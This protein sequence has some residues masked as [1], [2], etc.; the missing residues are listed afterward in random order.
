[1]HFTNTIFSSNSNKD[2]IS[3]NN[4]TFGNVILENSRTAE[5]NKDVKL[6]LDQA[7]AAKEKKDFN[8]VERIR[9]QVQKSHPSEYA[10]FQKQ[11]FSPSSA[12]G[13]TDD[14]KKEKTGV[15]SLIDFAQ[16]SAKGVGKPA[17]Q[18][19]ELEKERVKQI[20]L[21]RGWI[22]SADL[23]EWFRV[24]FDKFNLKEEVVY[25]LLNVAHNAS[26]KS[27]VDTQTVLSLWAQMYG[28]FPDT[29]KIV[30][31][32]N[33]TADLQSKY[34]SYG[35][36][37]ALRSMAISPK[38]NNRYD[39]DFDNET[40]NLIWQELKS[41]VLRAPLEDTSYL[42]AQWF[43]S[44]NKI[45]RALEKAERLQQISDQIDSIGN[46]AAA[47]MLIEQLT[48]MNKLLQSQGWYKALQGVIYS[49]YA[50]QKA[51]EVFS[52][53]LTNTSPTVET[54]TRPTM[55]NL[56]NQPS[57]SD[58]AKQ[59][60][61]SLNYRQVLAQAD[62]SSKM[63]DAE[64]RFNFIKNE[65]VKQLSTLKTGN[66]LVDT[67]IQTFVNFITNSNFID[68]L[69]GNFKNNITKSLSSLSNPNS[70]TKKSSNVSFNKVSQIYTSIFTAPNALK[71]VSMA[72]SVG[73]IALIIGYFRKNIE[74]YAKEPD[75]LIKF[76]L[77]AVNYLVEVLNKEIIGDVFGSNLERDSIFYNADGTV[78]TDAF[79]DFDA[80][81]LAIGGS[82]QDAQAIATL[83]NVIKR[84]ITM[85]EDLENTVNSQIER[86]VQAGS[87]SK[88]IR[89]PADTSAKF[90]QNLNALSKVIAEAISD[91]SML[92]SLYDRILSD[93]DKQAIDPL[94]ASFIGSGRRRAYSNQE[95]LRSKRQRYASIEVIKDEIAKFIR[96]NMLL[97]PIMA[98]VKKFN[99]LGMS[100]APLIAESKSNPNSLLKAM[101][102]IRQNEQNKI[103]KVQKKINEI[104]ARVPNAESY[105]DNRYIGI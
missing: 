10:E 102:A 95:K 20:A 72:G 13:T 82:I 50:G 60:Q 1:M 63:G 39:G 74:A 42:S 67:I 29:D 104:K 89:A 56:Q 33:T 35:L 24:F 17:R 99:N 101:A 54:E 66:S 64:K 21:S 34:R 62:N 77:L 27:G 9:D 58:V 18:R 96:L 68:F 69:N 100:L 45:S 55:Y 16:D 93:K 12:T 30:S 5:L 80:A 51:W 25:R 84:K 49:L 4:I 94:N 47:S 53:P 70:N 71:L 7:N 38:N 76:S 73:V 26:V 8:E 43:D 86:D 40:D 14:K 105:T 37:D 61:S 98:R 103:D 97:G 90:T 92:I 6:L 75:Q 44:E 57:S 91:S 32:I 81:V 19:F 31:I 79:K 22:P 36:F 59:N 41:L 28:V 46:N 83:E 15:D 11:Y 87:E 2:V 88:I 78:K 52:A 23:G 65:L 48:T 85:I 3:Q